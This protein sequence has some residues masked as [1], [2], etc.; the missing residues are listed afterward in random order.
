L[1]F[2]LLVLVLLVQVS[3]QADSDAGSAEELSRLQRDLGVVM[4]EKSSLQSDISGI[5][6]QLQVSVARLGQE[7]ASH[8]TQ[9]GKLEEANRDCAKSREAFSVEKKSLADAATAAEKDRDEAQAELAAARKQQNAKAVETAVLAKKAKGLEESM[10][11]VQK[12]QEGYSDR[13]VEVEAQLLEVQG[14]LQNKL[15]A[16]TKLAVDVRTSADAMSKALK[17]SKLL[18]DRYAL[19]LR[20]TEEQQAMIMSLQTMND[21]CVGTIARLNRNPLRVLLATLFAPL[22]WLLRLLRLRV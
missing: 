7:Q 2:V 4:A 10:A 6:S 20:R 22:N 9:V 17:E 19:A 15:I 1:R 3:S 18:K 12:S 16:N 8:K 14:A 11:E 21:E 5:Q 13:V